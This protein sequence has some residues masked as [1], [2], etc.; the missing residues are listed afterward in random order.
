MTRT[1]LS[2]ADAQI[3]REELTRELSDAFALDDL[4]RFA[5][6]VAGLISGR[7]ISFPDGQ[8]ASPYR[9]A[10]YDRESAAQL[11]ENA[12]EYIRSGPHD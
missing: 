7:F 3:K 10:L 12:A 6:S 1:H 11:F 4:C 8:P 2:N 9:T 5:S